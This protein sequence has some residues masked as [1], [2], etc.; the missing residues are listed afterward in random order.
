MHRAPAR[1]GCGQAAGMPG[2]VWEWVSVPVVRVCAGTVA[3]LCEA[4]GEVLSG[5]LGELRQYGE[6]YGE[7]GGGAG[8]PQGV[9]DL[10]ALS[11]S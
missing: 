2:K 4:T 9:G 6:V 1:A 5:V 11:K 7:G 8:V 10:W 3:E